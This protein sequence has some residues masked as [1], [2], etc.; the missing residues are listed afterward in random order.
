MKFK[1]YIPKYSE[2][3]ESTLKTEKMDRLQNCFSEIIQFCIIS[4]Y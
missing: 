2:F 1:I 4:F 3:F